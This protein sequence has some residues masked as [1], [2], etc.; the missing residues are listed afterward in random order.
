LN[1]TAIELN[2]RRG[3]T[4]T[5]APLANEQDGPGADSGEDFPTNPI[6]ANANPDE[7]DGGTDTPAEQSGAHGEHSGKSD[8]DPA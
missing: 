7:E 4:M 5:N 3:E 2:T 8:A 1:S 6:P